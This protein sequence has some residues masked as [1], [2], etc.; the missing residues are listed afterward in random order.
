LGHAGAIVKRRA[1]NLAHIGFSVTA[2]SWLP[3]TE[4][5]AAWHSEW[6]TENDGRVLPNGWYFT[7]IAMQIM[8]THLAGTAVGTSG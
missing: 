2:A 4:S 5:A 1:N 8:S 7:L 3:R 6:L